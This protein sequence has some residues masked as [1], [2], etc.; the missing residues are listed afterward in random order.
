MIARN[1]RIVARNAFT[2]MELLV[3]IAILVVLAGLG[4][5]YYMKHLDEARIDAAKIQVKTITQ[6]VEAYNIKH[7]D[8]PDNLVALTV[9]DADGSKPYLEPDAI[10]TPWGS[11]YG[12]D[13]SGANN[14]GNKPDIWAE[15]PQGKI[16][17]WSS[18]Q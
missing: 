3:V 13:K 10:K 2:L 7:G 12:Y 5:Y 6:A 1:T 15:S 8:Y 17:N 18:Q 4:G 9:K 16:G 11:E 14:G